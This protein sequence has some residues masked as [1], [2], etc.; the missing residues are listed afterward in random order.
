[1]S[2]N[3]KMLIYYVETKMKYFSGRTYITKTYF[4]EYP[5]NEQIIQTVNTNNEVYG[6]GEGGIVKIS[7]EIMECE[8]SC[9]FE[10]YEE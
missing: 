8:D 3:L 10:E 9:F 7:T 4:E 2:K 6:V 5:S 1:M